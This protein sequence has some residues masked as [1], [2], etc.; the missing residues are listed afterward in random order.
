MSTVKSF[1]LVFL[2]SLGLSLSAQVGN[3]ELTSAEQAIQLAW[4]QNPDLEVYCWCLTQK[5]IQS[6]RY[7]SSQLPFGKGY[8][9]HRVPW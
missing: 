2:L 3:I 6:P 9:R 1:A 5:K 8:Q 7:R 4:T